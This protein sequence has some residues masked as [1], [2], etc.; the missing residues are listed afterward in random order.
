MTFITFLS[1]IIGYNF[2]RF[3]ASDCYARATLSSRDLIDKS[4]R[5]DLDVYLAQR[6]CFVAR[7]YVGTPRNDILAL[8][9]HY[10]LMNDIKICL[11]GLGYVGLPLACLFSEKFEVC[12]YDY[13]QEKID[14]L[15]NG[16]DRTREVGDKLQNYK[17]EYSGDPSII[18]QANFIIV[19]V[20]TPI[21]EQNNP[22]LEPVIKASEAVGQ[23]LS[24][25]S[26]VVFE[27]TVWPGCTEEICLPII[28]RESGLKYNQDF[29]L[30]YSPERVNP[31]D[32]EHTID[33][34]V[35][36]VSGSTPETLKTVSEVYN[37]II[38]KVYPVSDL[39]TAE[40]AKVIENIQRDLNIALMNELSLI[41]SKMGLDTKAVID[42]A[43]SKWNFVKYYP[44][45]VGGH[46]IGVDPYYLTHKAHE[47]GYD[48]KVILAGRGINNYMPVYVAKTVAEELTKAG[49]ELKNAKVLVLGLTFKENVPDLRNSK[50]KEMIAALKQQ[51]VEVFGHDPLANEA[52]IESYFGFKNSRLE[53]LSKVDA[54]IMFSPHQ[55]FKALTLAKLKTMMNDQPVLFDLKRFYDKQEAESLGITYKC[56]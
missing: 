2:F 28:E 55:E 31:G 32:Q 27:S 51:G 11:V 53:D 16:Y 3:L 49:K 48:S 38:A 47:L 4:G 5:G 44:G 13:N 7:L 9:R 40:A 6:D 24:A 34:I 20:P 39:K 25:G 10:N 18:K 1:I 50:A 46:C 26:I 30:G 54:I 15:K 17:I 56:L 21:D 36:V 35:K 37:S 23:N 41:F 42:A 22:D 45:L 14:E 29:F 52:F 19:A 12:G 8:A 33:K 43:A